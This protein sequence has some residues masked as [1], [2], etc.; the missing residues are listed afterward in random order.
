MKKMLILIGTLLMAGGVFASCLGPFCWDDKGAYIG[1]TVFDGNGDG[2]PSMTIAQSS[3]TVPTA[4]G[5][6]IFCSNCAAAGGAGTLCV[7]TATAV[8]SYVLSTGTVCK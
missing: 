2:T 5:Q 3:S 8:N 1:G 7:S 6:E 4:K